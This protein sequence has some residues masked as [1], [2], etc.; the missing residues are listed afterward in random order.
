MEQRYKNTLPW[1]HQVSRGNVQQVHVHHQFGRNVSCGTS[2][3]PVSDIGVY[4]T[5]QV[6]SA[7]ALRIKAGGNAADTAAGAGARSIRLTG[8]HANGDEATEIIATAGASASVPTNAQ[9]IRLYEAA[10]VN[11]GTYGTQAAGS[12]VGNITIENAAGTED[13][14][15]IRLN[16]FP[17]NQRRRKRRSILTL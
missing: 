13:W 9:L 11:S 17:R 8:I 6:G 5:P 10:V 1:G 12:H 7:T 14:A 16:G 15:Q 3:A 2:Y 4:R